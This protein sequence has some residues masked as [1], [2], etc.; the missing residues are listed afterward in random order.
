VFGE[1][2]IQLARVAGIRIGASPSWFLVLLFVIWSLSE[3]FQETLQSSQNEAYVVA[4]IAAVLFFGSIVLHELGHAFEARRSGMRVE[5]I[6]LWFFGGIAK[7]DRDSESPGEEFRVAAA[8]PAV[9]LLLFAAA[10]AASVALYG[11]DEVTD[12]IQL[13]PGVADPLELLVSWFAF[14]NLAL[15]VFNLLPAFPLDGGR[16]ARAIV[17]K[18]TSDRTKGTIAAARLGQGFG[19]LL[20]AYGAYVLIDDWGEDISGLWWI[21]LGW[22]IAGSAKS[23]A[24]SARVTDRLEGV[25]VGMIMDEHPVTLPASTR[26]I[27]AEEWFERYDADWFAVVDEEGRLLG[28]AERERLAAAVNAG[29][30]A[31]AAHEIL[32]PGE[33]VGTEQPLQAVINAEPLRRLGAVMAVD[34]AGILRGVLTVEQVRRALTAALP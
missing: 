30:P 28:I 29:Q 21:V 9:T 20:L 25:T 18:A 11:A 24:V 14:M 10:A 23:A 27:D 34:Q 1:R 15:F 22:L 16:I 33:P 4:V 13:E 26:L 2:S 12:V 6:D 5:G 8:G 32:S 3:S 7:L 31:L 19:F 17:W